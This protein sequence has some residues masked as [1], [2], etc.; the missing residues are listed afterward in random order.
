MTQPKQTTART[1]EVTVAAISQEAAATALNTA[2][3]LRD[4]SE[5]LTQ[6]FIDAGLAT[7][8]AGTRATR[9]YLASLAK[10]RKEWI[11]RSD[12]VSEKAASLSPAD[13][14]YSFKSE[15]EDGNARIL[16]GTRKAFEFFTAPLLASTRR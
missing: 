13:I 10:V 14:D 16:E 7:Q 5:K 2:T 12:E 11:K 4:A 15:I 3:S 8:E 6:E 1:N 9:E